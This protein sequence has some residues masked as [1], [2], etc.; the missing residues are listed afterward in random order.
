[1][2]RTLQT[3]LSLV[4]VAASLASCVKETLKENSIPAGEKIQVA[5]SGSIGEFVPANDG[6]KANAESVVRVTWAATNDKVY[7]YDGSAYL[8]SLDV[9]PNE[10]N[11]SHALL[12]GT[13]NPSE[14]TPTNLSLVYVKGAETA[15]VINGGKISVDISTQSATGVADVP[16]VLYAT[17]EYDEE[18]LTKEN[19]FV[20]FSFATSVMTVNCT[21]LPVDAN[22]AKIN[23]TKAE[24]DGVSTACELT[25]DGTGVTAVSGTTPGTITRTAGF[26]QADSRGSFK[27]AL[28][29]DP[30]TPEARNI[31][32]FQDSKVSG[33]AFTSTTLAEGNS[34]N[35]VYQMEEYIS[36]APDG[37]LSG[38]FTVS[39]P[40]GIPN[41]GDETK[42]HF[43]KGNLWYGKV[44][45]AAEATF[46]FEGKQY[47]FHTYDSTNGLWGFFGW[48]GTSSTVFTSAPEIY[49][50]S[51]SATRSDY[52]NVA[53]ESLKADWGKTIGDGNTWRTLTQKEWEYLF[54]KHSYKWVSVNN[55][56]GYV[57]APDQVTLSE[58]KTSYTETELNDAN[59]V[60]LPAAGCRADFM[61]DS[62]IDIAGVGEYGQYWS[63][64][65]STNYDELANTVYFE[66][67]FVGTTD[68]YPSPRSFGHSVRLVTE[69]AGGY[70]PAVKVT[71]VTMGKSKTTIIV[72]DKETLTATVAPANATN[73][74]ITWSS[75]DTSVATVDENGEVTGVAAGSANIFATTADGNFTAVCLVTVKPLITT[76]TAKR[77]GDIDVNWVQLWK[78]GPKFAEYNVGVTD[79]KAESYGGYY[80]WGGT[81]NNDPN[82]P[83]FLWTDDHNTGFSELSHTGEDI[84]DTATKLWG[85]NWRMPTSAELEELIANCDVEWTDSYKGSGKQGRIFT[86]K[87]AYSS[88]SVFLPVAG[89]CNKG[90]V[91]N[92]DDNGRFWSSTPSDSNYAYVLYVGSGSQDVTDY[93]RSRSHG[94]SVRAVL[95]E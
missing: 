79:G 63:S 34:Y 91:Y 40:N 87:G 29:A 11:H 78:D 80:T 82:L 85:S 88:N 32:V 31:L 18:K 83:D 3:L 69:S 13:I 53:G 6:T 72:D 45:G 7:V 12:S 42:V 64:S 93:M 61:S 86:G 25:V 58:G 66:N 48:V 38:E 8:G 9:T 30:A 62:S 2:K 95:A 94:Y 67:S 51:T 24:I 4:V 21:N 60:F 84:T 39:D 26:E 89:Y 33:A 59:L 1:M 75:S 52:G 37:M 46:Q 49:G 41:S 35:T 55:V 81:Y 44:E 54:N 57:I 68:D 50:V 77:T 23:I 47:E 73:K 43:S 5:V 22:K 36:N 28:A 16:F 71:G 27:L 76:G 19:E 92:Q 17:I 74:Q 15:P 20:P 90:T 56:F 14:A 65:S 10:D 70:A